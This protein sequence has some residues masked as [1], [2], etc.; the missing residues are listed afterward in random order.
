MKPHKYQQH[1]VQFALDSGVCFWMVDMGLGKTLMTLLAQNHIDEPM[2]VIAPLRP[3]YSTWP[4]E[5]K[6][7]FPGKTFVI[8]HGKDK[9]YNYSQN[10]DF[11]LMNPHGIK[12]LDGKMSKLKPRFKHLVVDESSQWKSHSTKR[13]KLLKRHLYR[14]KHRFLLSGTP[15]PQGLMDLWSQYYILDGG[16]RLGKSITKFRAKYF[17]L[18]LVNNQFPQYTP[19]PGALEKV[20][21]EVR[22][23]TFRLDACDHIELPDI[24]YNNINL[25]LNR[26]LMD[27]YRQLEKDFLLEIGQIEVEAFNSASL[28]SKLRQFIQGGLYDGEGKDRTWHQV[29]TLRV[30]ALEALIEETSQPILC[31]IQFRFELEMLRARFGNSVPYIGGGVSALAGAKTIESWNKGDVPLLVCHPAALSHGANLQ[32]GGHI[33]LWYG[34]PWS[35]EQYQQLIARLHRQGQLNT[36]VINH[37]LMHETIDVRIAKALKNKERVQTAILEYTKEIQ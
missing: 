27:Q 37:L 26:S 6:K 13:F 9:D 32:A 12:W 34:L 29:H 14:F 25:T 7:W 19:K 36:V 31:A 8:L 10:A 20:M 11:Y 22:D 30:D 21:G 33:L 35:L 16:K 28:S 2:L 3:L 17:D 1:A 5:I 23:I 24:V 15:S 4:D 18:Y